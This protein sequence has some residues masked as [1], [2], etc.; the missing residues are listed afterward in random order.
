MKKQGSWLYD[1]LSG[2]A[3]ADG[4]I[5][6]GEPRFPALA[7]ANERPCSRQRRLQGCGRRVGD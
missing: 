4:T 1:D 7:M 2:L 3:T 5:S 6:A